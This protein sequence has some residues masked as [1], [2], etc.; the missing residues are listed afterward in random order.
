MGLPAICDV[1]W[2]WL[3][4]QTTNGN[5]PLLHLPPVR[6]RSLPPLSLS[7]GPFF[8]AN[9]ISLITVMTRANGPTFFLPSERAS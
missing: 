6:R 9:L 1:P 3:G 5:D 4:S 8:S 7:L 2:A